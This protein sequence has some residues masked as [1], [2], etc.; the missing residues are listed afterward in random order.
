MSFLF[1]G[2]Y[3]RVEAIRRLIKSFLEDAQS[4]ATKRQSRQPAREA[5]AEISCSNRDA[6]GQSATTAV[7]PPVGARCTFQPQENAECVGQERDSMNGKG[8]NPIAQVVNI[9]AGAD[10]TAFFLAVGTSLSNSL[11]LY[12]VFYV[13]GLLQPHLAFISLASW[14]QITVVHACTFPCIGRCT[15]RVIDLCIYLSCVVYIAS[16]YLFG[17]SFVSG[18]SR[19]P[20]CALYVC[21]CLSL[22]PCMG[23]HARTQVP[24]SAT[25][26]YV[27]QL[28]FA[29]ADCSAKAAQLRLT[30]TFQMFVRKKRRLS[31]GLFPYS[32]PFSRFSFCCVPPTTYRLHLTIFTFAGIYTI[33]SVAII[34]VRLL[35]FKAPVFSA[36]V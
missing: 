32:Y 24:V 8:G 18:C 22:R 16:E 35:A 36:C 34:Y 20:V 14:M 9:G 6:S 31:G 28:R 10:T 19:I 7:V 3:S 17:A 29:N 2:Y 21:V 33:T 25:C 12:P 11:L 5:E 26:L 23:A 15:P 13:G 1:K 27:V 4:L 30:L